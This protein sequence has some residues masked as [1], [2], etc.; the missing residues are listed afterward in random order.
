MDEYK[1]EATE[2]ILDA[3]LEIIVEF[4]AGILESFGS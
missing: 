3:L 2:T 4:F 1:D